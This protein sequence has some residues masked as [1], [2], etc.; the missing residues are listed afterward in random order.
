MNAWIL[1]ASTLSPEAENLIL[2]GMHVEENA[3]PLCKDRLN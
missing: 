3:T 1:Q 2:L